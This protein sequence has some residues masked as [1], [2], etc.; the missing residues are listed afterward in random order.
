M[1]ILID[2]VFSPPEDTPLFGYQRTGATSR[3]N[4]YCIRES[5]SIYDSVD[6]S[7]PSSGSDEAN[8]TRP[9]RLASSCCFCCQVILA[10]LLWCIHIVLLSSHPCSTSVVHSYS[11]A[12]NPPGT[13]SEKEEACHEIGGGRISDS[14]LLDSMDGGR[15]LQIKHEINVESTIIQRGTTKRDRD[16]P[17][18]YRV[19]NL[20][21]FKYLIPVRASK[22]TKRKWKEKGTRRSIDQYESREWMVDRR[23]LVLEALWP[24]RG[25]LS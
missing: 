2:G 18:V 8:S 5:I 14:E 9:S 24:E 15:A 16:Q 12:V 6:D 4:G 20:R 22:L 25:L 21:F 17:L 3:V 13:N 7:L 10:Q 1:D 11:V 19:P 23:L